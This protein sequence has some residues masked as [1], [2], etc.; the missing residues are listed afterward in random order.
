MLESGMVVADAPAITNSCAGTVTAVPGSDTIELEDGAIGI[1]EVCT[2]TVNVTAEAGGS[3][4]W[5]GNVSVPLA[6]SEGW[7]AIKDLSLAAAWRFA[8]PWLN[9]DLLDGRLSMEGNYQLSWRD[10]VAFEIVEGQAQL[11][12][13][14]LV[15]RDTAAL[16]DTSINL[17]QLDIGDVSVDSGTSAVTI[18]SISG[19]GLQVQG[20]SEGAQVLSLIHI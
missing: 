19:Q 10:D 16:A 6:Q 5:E 1:G 12:S 11:H 9:F 15:P 14:A 18:G 3:L 7:L 13:L 17:N 4:R 20:W 8:R 2:I